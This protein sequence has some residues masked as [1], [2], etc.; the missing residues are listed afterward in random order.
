[1]WILESEIRDRVAAVPP[2]SIAPL[3]WTYERKNSVGVNDDPTSNQPFCAL[4][5]ARGCCSWPHAHLLR[6]AT[7]G[8]IASS[9]IFLQKNQVI[10]GSSF[11][12]SRAPACVGLELRAYLT[13]K[14][15]AKSQ[16]QVRRVEQANDLPVCLK[17]SLD[18]SMKNL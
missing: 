8:I 2:P 16:T 15:A 4:R 18:P 3:E 5:E 6:N 12:L 10:I 17:L 1:M 14:R 13:T 9:S 11:G 7:P